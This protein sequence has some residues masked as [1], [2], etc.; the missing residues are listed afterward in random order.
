M[1]GHTGMYI[2]LV[3]SFVPAVMNVARNCQWD[4]DFLEYFRELFYFS[5]MNV[6]ITCERCFIVFQEAIDATEDIRKEFENEGAVE[7]KQ[8]HNP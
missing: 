1:I 6:A 4:T 2:R 7:S 8:I 3:E 5:D